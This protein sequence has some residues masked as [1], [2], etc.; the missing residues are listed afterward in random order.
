MDI[1][2]RLR[3]LSTIDQV[4]RALTAVREELV[5]WRLDGWEISRPISPSEIDLDFSADEQLPGMAPVHA[6]PNDLYFEVEPGVRVGPRRH[7]RTTPGR[8][9]DPLS[10]CIDVRE[11]LWSAQTLPDMVDG[12]DLLDWQLAQLQER[13]YVLFHP[14]R[15]RML[16][17]R[18]ACCTYWH[19]QFDRRPVDFAA[20]CAALKEPVPV[21][22]YALRSEYELWIDHPSPAREDSKGLWAPDDLADVAASF[23]AALPGQQLLNRVGMRAVTLSKSGITVGPKAS[24]PIMQ[25][26]ALRDLM[27]WQW[28][29]SRPCVYW[30]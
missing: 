4:R 5:A 2:A 15:D 12:L 19:A 21:R 11:R 27:Q 25:S 14:V 10:G 7:L 23:L 9:F 24:P 8:P 29:I 17:L 6:L 22:P 30:N 28:D 1:D 3:G 18:R 26:S 20:V 13:S 16:T